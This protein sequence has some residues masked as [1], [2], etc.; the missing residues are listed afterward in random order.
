MYG[1]WPDFAGAYV[2]SVHLETHGR[3]FSPYGSRDL[4][5][6]IHWWIGADDHYPD[7]PRHYDQ[8]ALHHRITLAFH[9]SGVE[10]R[11]FQFSNVQFD[12]L[13]LTTQPTSDGF[14]DRFNVSM[15]GAFELAFTA[16][17]VKVLG[18][19]PCDEYGRDRGT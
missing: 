7:A 18:V 13:Q 14:P 3:T 8:D 11:T 19:V 2:M 1:E 4:I 9:A 17:Q 15:T 12:A 6:T 16:S 5:L 10:L